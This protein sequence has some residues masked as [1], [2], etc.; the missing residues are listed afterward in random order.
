MGTAHTDGGVRDNALGHGE[1]SRG[2]PLLP[3]TQMAPSQ[4]SEAKLATYALFLDK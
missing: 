1:V 4:E 3:R 2:A